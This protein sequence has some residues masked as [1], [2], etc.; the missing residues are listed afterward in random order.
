[1]KL[2]PT[3]VLHPGVITSHGDGLPHFINAPRL[4][5]LYGVRMDDC[6]IAPE[7]RAF[8][9]A[10]SWRADPYA[11]LIHLYPR[12]DDIYVLPEKST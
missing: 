1:M 6:A 12:A 2:K 7:P 9:T 8:D 11:G 4:A 3:Y 10:A 5:G